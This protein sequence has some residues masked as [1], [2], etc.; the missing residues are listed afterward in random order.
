MPRFARRYPRFT[1]RRTRRVARG[2]RRRYRR[3]RRRFFR[4]RRRYRSRFVC[5]KFLYT[6]N[7]LSSQ[8]Y[9]EIAP[10][11]DDVPQA[12]AMLAMYKR[13][14]IKG[15]NLRY[16]SDIRGSFVQF[17]QMWQS[18]GRLGVSPMAYA[19]EFEPCP[20]ADCIRMKGFYREFVAHRDFAVNR[21]TLWVN[22]DKPEGKRNPWH[23]DTKAR[24]YGLYLRTINVTPE[25]QAKT[26]RLGKFYVTVYIQFRDRKLSTAISTVPPFESKKKEKT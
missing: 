2:V 7:V 21:R 12:K 11:V 5:H 17:P 3:I 25:M 19:G 13:F 4:R 26:E 9:F 18:C 16:R 22:G 24:H 15:M 23:A 6:V 8:P 10:C 20:S 14:R 1:W